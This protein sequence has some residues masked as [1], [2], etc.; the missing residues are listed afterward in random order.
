[1]SREAFVRKATGL[2]REWS[3]W[4]A[5]QFA[6]L[7]VPYTVFT[8]FVVLFVALSYP[9]V[10]FYLASLVCAVFGSIALFSYTSLCCAFPRSGAD[11]VLISRIVHPAAGFMMSETMYLVCYFLW[12]AYTSW[13][14][15]EFGVTPALIATGFILNNA[16]ISAMG[17]WT[18]TPIGLYV[19]GAI[20]I[21]ACTA[22]LMPGMKYFFKVQ[23]V[24]F[25]WALVHSIVMLAIF[26]TSSHDYFIQR[27][28]EFVQF[29]NPEMTDAYH[30]IIDSAVQAGVDLNPSLS[31]ASTM[32]AIP[33]VWM[34]VSFSAQMTMQVMGEVKRAE[35]IKRIGGGMI[36]AS[37]VGLA[38]G[39]IFWGLINNVVGTEFLYAISYAFGSGANPL[40]TAPYW[41]YFGLILTSSV[42]LVWLTAMGFGPMQMAFG[43]STNVPITGTR[44]LFSVSF[45]RLFPKSAWLTTLHKRWRSTVNAYVFWIISSL[46]ALAFFTF[47]PQLQAWLLA[48]VFSNV[49]IQTMT[50]ICAAAFPFRMKDAF[51]ASPIGKYMVG[52]VPLITITGIIGIAFYVFILI[53]GILVPGIGLFTTETLTTIIVCYIFFIIF[54]YVMRA[55]RMRQGIEVDLAYKAIPPE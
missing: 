28:N 12:Q 46:I 13:F 27:F 1:M 55:Y 39:A 50:Q 3:L 31:W 21:V 19:I 16:T 54:F 8:S 41:L 43:N 11:Y 33:Y 14:V 34:G 15:M 51:K 10:G 44:I 52:R 9:G 24:V 42:P 48:A 7:A 30:R 4:N 47:I 36:L 5:F 45:D 26:A 22:L 53:E 40:P 37:L 29:L 38:F 6:Y 25:V 2:T 20:F 23:W 18:A 32:A 49:L 35:S 17:L